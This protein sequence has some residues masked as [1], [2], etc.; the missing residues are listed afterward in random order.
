MIYEKGSFVLVPNRKHLRTLSLGARALYVEFCSFSDAHGICFP[1]RKVLAEHIQMSEDSVDRFIYELVN[2][3]LLTKTSRKEK[4]GG[5]SSNLYQ[6]MILPM[7]PGRMGDATPPR[8][9]TDTPSR[10]DAALTIPT[11]LT[12]NTANAD[13][14]KITEEK[15]DKD[16]EVRPP[17]KSQRA[18]NAQ[19]E[20]LLQ[21]AEKRRGFPFVNRAKQ[22]AALKKARESGISPARLKQRWMDLENEEWRKENGFDWGSDVSSFDKRA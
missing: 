11:S 5:Y 1:S 17:K 9:D 22:Y 18:V 7:P 2:A 21:W 14:L 6:I 19:Y 4:N 13:S 20:A 10:V 8:A 16:G 15:L 3:G 12:I